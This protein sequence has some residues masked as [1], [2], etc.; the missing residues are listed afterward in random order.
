MREDLIVRHTNFS[1]LEEHH[2]VKVTVTGSIPV[3]LPKIAWQTFF[4]LFFENLKAATKTQDVQ[5]FSIGS[6]PIDPAGD[7]SSAVEQFL[8]EKWSQVIVWQTFAAFNIY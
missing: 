4:L 8:L 2:S 1:S 5:T 6:N 7:Y 3:S